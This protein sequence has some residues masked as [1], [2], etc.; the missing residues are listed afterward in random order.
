M[1]FFFFFS[2][3]IERLGLIRLVQVAAA[4]AAVN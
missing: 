4:F 2:P 3:Q 1:S